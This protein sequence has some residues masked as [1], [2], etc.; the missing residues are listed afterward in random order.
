M[1]QC[2]CGGTDFHEKDEDTAV[3]DSC[4][5]EYNIVHE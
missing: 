5:Q 3:C 1:F 2:E 4:G